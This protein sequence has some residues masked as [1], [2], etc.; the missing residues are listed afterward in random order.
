MKIFSPK[1]IDFFELFDNASH[2]V[3]KA[4]SLL[5]AVFQDMDNIE[6]ISREIR[7]CEKEGDMMTRDIIKKLNQTF[8][9]PLEHEDL[10]SLAIKVDDVVD[11]IWA[12]VNKLTIFRLSFPTKEAIAMANEILKTCEVMSKA[13]IA[14]RDKKYS[15]VEEYCIDIHSLENR[16][17]RLYR[18]AL[19]K[20]FDENK[21][22][23]EI[24][25]W[26][27]VYE[28]LEKAANACEGVAN[29][30]QTIVLKYA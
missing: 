24:I 15:F 16:V 20:L 23:I 30:L 26:K 29:S 27:E 13:L 22:P 7:K 25:K 4:A 14:L 3:I 11:M 18:D 1:S 28:Y 21:D 9:P 12:S 2:N 8:S 17:D 5:V 19:G 6:M 10:H